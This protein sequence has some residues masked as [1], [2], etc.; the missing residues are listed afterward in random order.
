[1]RPLKL[2]C[3]S[4]AGGS[5]VGFVRWKSLLDPS[6]SIYP[7]DL[8]GRGKK[9]SLPFYTGIEEAVKDLSTFIMNAA[10]SEPYAFIG[11]S[12]GTIIAYEMCHYLKRVGFNEPVAVFFSGRSAPDVRNEE[13]HIHHLAD[14]LFIEEIKQLGH[15]PDELFQ[16]KELL[17]IFVPILKADYKLIET[18]SYKERIPLTSDFFLFV[19]KE[20][21][22]TSTEQFKEEWARHTDGACD[23][24]VYEGGHFFIYEQTPKV[25]ETI[26]LCLKKASGKK[27][28]FL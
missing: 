2:F 13:N 27:G 19:G 3:F 1:L 5:S 8:N 24:H 21:Q 20:D 22:D 14:E 15:S 12:M 26:H 17:K 25:I 16:N 10:G 18:Y 9:G 6:I 11:H 4:H 7:V 28:V 23:L